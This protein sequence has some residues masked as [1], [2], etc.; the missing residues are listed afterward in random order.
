MEFT[1]IELFNDLATQLVAENGRIIDLHNEMSCIRI[2]LNAKFLKIYCKR[3][4][5]G[6]DSS[7]YCSLLF[8]DVSLGKVDIVPTEME[9]VKT[10]NVLYRGRFENSGKVYEFNESGHPYFYIEFESGIS[11]EFFCSRA[12]LLL[13]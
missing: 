1:S 5:S 12:E 9:E 10:I 11:L 7:V 8:S 4:H 13:E 2:E 3:L 6:D